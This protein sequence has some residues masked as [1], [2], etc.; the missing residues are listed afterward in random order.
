MG[1]LEQSLLQW[2]HSH[3]TNRE[4]ELTEFLKVKQIWGRTRCRPTLCLISASPALFPSPGANG[5]LPWKWPHP[6]GR[7][8]DIRTS[9]TSNVKVLSLQPAK[10]ASLFPLLQTPESAN[11]QTL[12]PKRALLQLPKPSFALGWGLMC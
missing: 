2:S 1:A 5:N 4:T 3:H 12:S 10:Q 9:P 7:S 8:S 6:G 11:F